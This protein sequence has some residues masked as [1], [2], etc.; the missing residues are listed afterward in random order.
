MAIWKLGLCFGLLCLLH[1]PSSALACT[2]LAK[3]FTSSLPANGAQGVPIDVAPVIRGSWEPESVVWEAED[4]TRVP[5]DLVSGPSQQFVGRIAELVPRETLRP[6]AR[7]FIRANVLLGSMPES[8]EFTTGDASADEVPK[9]PPQVAVSVLN[10]ID[11]SCVSGDSVVCASVGQTTALLEVLGVDGTLLLR[12]VIDGNV[13]TYVTAPGCVRISARSASGELSAPRELC[14]AALATRPVRDELLGFH[15]C[16]DGEFRPRDGSRTS[17][18][19]DA[20]VTATSTSQQAATGAGDVVGAD[21]GAEAATD[22]DAPANVAHCAL[23]AGDGG[24]RARTSL[25]AL[26][27]A[28]G[29][30]WSRRRERRAGRASE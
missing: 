8:I 4:G 20:S 9:Q 11:S 16:R 27:V 29:G 12:D 15:E 6:M 7:Y 14:D 30:L 3:T 23:A 28:A 13:F 17:G 1:A 22:A 24:G 5:F 26:A 2:W 25:L 19:D 18:G 10:G 21:A